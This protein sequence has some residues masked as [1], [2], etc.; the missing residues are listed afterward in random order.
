VAAA[1]TTDQVLGGGA[2]LPV[3]VTA[4]GNELRR[5]WQENAQE[6]GAIT[7][8][9]T[10]NLVVLCA[11]A[12]EAERATATIAALAGEHPSRAFVVEGSDDPARLEAFLAAH[13]S[14][15][16]GGRHVCCEQITLHVGRDNRRRAAG[17]IVPLLV[18]DLPV[19]VWVPGAPRWDDP[20]LAR[21]LDV[22]DR[23]VL[24]SRT[25]SDPPAFVAELVRARRA[26]AWA[27]GDF[28]WSRLTEWRE[29]IACL[30]DEPSTRAL[31]ARL[32]EVEVRYG[33]GGSA[34]AAA[35][36]AGGAQD[37]IELA[38]RGEG[39]TGTANATL[40]AGDDATPGAIAQ[41]RLVAKEPDAVLSVAFEPGDSGLTARVELAEACA[42]PARRPFPEQAVERLLGDQLDA[43]GASPLYDR[44]LARAVALL[45]T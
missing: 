25:A 44:A 5:L 21:L 13:C 8:A 40:Q 22:A 36:L 37:R 11:D 15:R 12:A 3:N 42:L 31:P 38:R 16:A 18:P 26:D 9:C 35:L 10:R 28:E 2:A 24:D 1:V 20:L 34:V 17:A 30:F 29:A 6:G 23:L 4:L 39:T 45:S 7:R 32:V 27:P 14:L 41:V 43:P 19:F 33:R